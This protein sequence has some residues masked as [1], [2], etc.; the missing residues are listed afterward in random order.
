LNLLYGSGVTVTGA[1][2]LLN[3]EM[4][5]F[6]VKPGEANAFGLVQGEANSIAPGKRPLSSMAPTVV[7]DKAGRV[8]V[9]TG[10]R[11]GA[12]IITA[13]FQVVSNV[14]DFGMDVYAAVSPPRLHH[15]HLPDQI[16]YEE[17]GLPD[18]DVKAL[19]AMG[20]KVNAFWPDGVAPTIVRKGDMWTA[21]PDPRRGGGA[22]GY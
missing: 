19:E 11:G 16:S 5:D 8:V 13:T 20:H 15:Q 18:A 4:N 3:D 22:E 9:V 6:A 21:A 17:G 12:R 10:A 1:G 14:L 7:V 2:F